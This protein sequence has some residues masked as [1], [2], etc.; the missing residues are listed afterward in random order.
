MSFETLNTIKPTIGVFGEFQNGKSTLINCLLD[1]KYARTGG[2]GLSVTSYNTSY[3]FNETT[4][5]CYQLD[6][7]TIINSTVNEYLSASSFPGN[8]VMIEA[9][10]WKPILE[11]VS[12]LDTPGFS[13]SNRDNSVAKT[14]IDLTDVGIVV[15]NNRG[16]S[17]VEKG[18]FTLLHSR[19]IPF[20][21][22]MN[23]I[24]IRGNI[25]MW[26]PDED[27]NKRK[28]EEVSEYLNVNNVKP[29][30]IGNSPVYLTNL[31]W[32]WFGSGG[33]TNDSDADEIKTRIDLYSERILKYKSSDPDSYIEMSR[34]LP[35]KA[36]ITNDIN[37][38]F[39]ILGNRVKKRLFSAFQLWEEKINSL[40]FS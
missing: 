26:R 21:I 19:G 23:C 18:L 39:P 34:F 15:I 38:G 27:Y 28:V 35:F 17:E 6:N 1:G 30:C 8:L 32:F 36:A 40:R 9:L 3:L 2:Q 20:Y 13:A 7:G 12:L 22:L 37:W 31:L 11:H 10:L 24:D 16:I 4:R 29:I 25:K 14:A 33:Y 5:L